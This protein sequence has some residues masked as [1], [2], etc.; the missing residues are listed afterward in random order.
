MMIEFK[1]VAF[2]SYTVILETQA[3]RDGQCFAPMPGTDRR[4]KAQI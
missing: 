3:E 1:S 4:L 2:F